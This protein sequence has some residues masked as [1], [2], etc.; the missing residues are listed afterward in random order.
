MG[1]ATRVI[2]FV[3]SRVLGYG[4]STWIIPVKVNGVGISTVVVTTEI[5][6]LS[7]TANDIDSMS[8]RPRVLSHVDVNLA[9]GGSAMSVGSLGPV[10]LGIGDCTMSRCKF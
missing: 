8:L 5:I 9:K 2:P 7:E 10:Q 6:I 4:E 3:R 1:A